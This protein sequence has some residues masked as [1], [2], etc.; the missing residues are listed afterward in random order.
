MTEAEGWEWVQREAYLK[1]G[2]TSD[3]H[4]GLHHSDHGEYHQ[5]YAYYPGESLNILSN[6]VHRDPP[7]NTSLSFCSF[8]S[9]IAIILTRFAESLQ[10]GNVRI[11]QL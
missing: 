5:Q 11:F 9:D 6:L 3:R 8:A 7:S 2:Q 10:R 1:G 4:A